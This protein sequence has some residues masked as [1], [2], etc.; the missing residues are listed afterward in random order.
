MDTS[1]PAPSRWSQR[2]AILFCVAVIVALWF[3]SQSS[4]ALNNKVERAGG[5][6]TKA[7]TAPSWI[8]NTFGEGIA[9]LFDSPKELFLREYVPE[10]I[11]EHAAEV[12][13]FEWIV[14]NGTDATDEDL[15]PL[16]GHPNLSGVRLDY[17]QVSDPTLKVLATLPKLKFLSLSLTKVTPQGL[18]DFKK[19]KPNV[20]VAIDAATEVGLRPYIDAGIASFSDGIG[21]LPQTTSSA[22]FPGTLTI[23][24][25]LEEPLV[26]IASKLLI[27]ELHLQDLTASKTVAELVKDQ[28]IQWL[29]LERVELTPEVASAFHSLPLKRVE[30][31]DVVFTSG[32]AEALSD[33]S[34]DE[35]QMK[36][37]TFAEGEPE[38]I[39]ELK[40][41]NGS[42][43]GSLNLASVDRFP[44]FN[45]TSLNISQLVLPKGLVPFSEL[46]T[47]HLSVHDMTMS[48]SL[49]AQ[50]AASAKDALSFDQVEIENDERDVSWIE[51]CRAQ[52]VSLW[53]IQLST[54]EFQRLVSQQREQL[55]LYS[56]TLEADATPLFADISATA[57]ATNQL[58][59]G[60]AEQLVHSNVTDLAID[61]TLADDDVLRTISNMKQLKR[62]S[63]NLKDASR[64]TLDALTALPQLE[65]CFIGL[66]GLLPVGV[67]YWKL[68]SEHRSNLNLRVVLLVRRNQRVW[69]P[70][71]AEHSGFNY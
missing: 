58:T 36:N 3:A 54:E 28:P 66:D 46:S 2:L 4:W 57:F 7:Q 39:S 10:G 14:L 68:L 38:R 53:Q 55:A 20:E 48:S 47:S 16:A 23:N 61:T 21:G 52:S 69:P 44:K 59:A 63:L 35:L 56:V 64:T 22:K 50:F 25:S 32:S 27:G 29:K 30:L 43:S 40:S 31:I 1:Q 60:Q 11:L 49:A 65:H 15:A 71:D 67:D 70:Y 9:S 12:E 17:T 51:S 33:H 26:G 24:A 62:L 5:A 8:R 13:S 6:I 41:H 19:A 18:T 37:V 45:C 42:L 34:L